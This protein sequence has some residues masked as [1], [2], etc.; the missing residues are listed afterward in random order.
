MGV[1]FDYFAAATDDEAVAVLDQLGGPSETMPDVLAVKGIEPVVQLGTL[2]SLLEGVERSVVSQ[3]ERSGRVIAHADGGERL[4]VTLSD[5]FQAAL[6]AASRERLME[7]A[8]PWARSEEFWDRVDT[9]ALA[10]FLGRL[11]AL[12]RT[13]TADGRRLYCWVCV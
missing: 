1:L 3:R 2:E 8:E 6:A 5:E 11:A 12:A 7:V 10:D 9:A 13:A 4:V